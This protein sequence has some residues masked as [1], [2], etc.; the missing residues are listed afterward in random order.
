[1]FLVGKGDEGGESAT[2][3]AVFLY[4]SPERP[5]PSSRGGDLLLLLA[6][7][8]GNFRQ[9]SIHVFFI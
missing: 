5:L 9:I 4:A 6:L 1:M 2:F 3:A 8:P 7:Q